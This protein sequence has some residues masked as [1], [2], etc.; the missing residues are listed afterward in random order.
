ML[1]EIGELATLNSI[2]TMKI[3]IDKLP[4]S[5]I[6]SWTG[7]LRGKYEEVQSTEARAFLEGPRCCQ[8]QKI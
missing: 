4:E 7:P 8:P 1:D 2:G 5:M 6:S 3:S